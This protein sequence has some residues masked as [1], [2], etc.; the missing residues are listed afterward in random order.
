MLLNC[1][2]GEDFFFFL[3]KTLECPL[4]CKEIQPVHPRGNQSWIF[5][6]RTDAEAETLILWLPGGQTRTNSFEKNQKQL[7][8][9]DPDAGKDWRQKEK[10]T[11]EDEMIGWHH[12]HDGQV[13]VG[14]RI[15]WWTG[16]PGVLQSMGSQRVGHNWVTEVSIS[17]LRYCF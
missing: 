10:G 9:K 5:T 4:D 16:K 6:V 13:W 2:V 14:S 8:W 12:W 3:E 15:Q 1:G 7:I 11:T 17:F